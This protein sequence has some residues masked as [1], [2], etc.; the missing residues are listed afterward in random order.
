MTV[1]KTNDQDSYFDVD[2]ALRV[3]RGSGYL[4]HALALARKHL[5]HDLYLQMLIEDKKDFIGAVKYISAL[6][7]SLVK[8]EK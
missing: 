2:T 4:D 5:R 6:N 7:F 8:I 3:L 1:F